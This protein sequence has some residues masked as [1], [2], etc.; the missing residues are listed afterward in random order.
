MLLTPKKQVKL[1]HRTSLELNGTSAQNRT[2][3][4]TFCAQQPAK[5]G[6]FCTVEWLIHGSTVKCRA[7]GLQRL[8]GARADT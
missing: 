8:L 1:I 6:E 7:T 4:G 3:N 5:S 2:E